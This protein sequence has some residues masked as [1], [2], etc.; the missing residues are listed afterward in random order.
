MRLSVII[1]TKNEESQIKGCLDSIKWTDE[2]IVVDS[3]S[4]DRTL[5]IAKRYNTKIFTDKGDDFSVKRNLGL[6]KTS[7]EW[8]FYVDADERV[9]PELREE[10]KSVISNQEAVVSAYKIPRKNFY[11]GNNEW[12]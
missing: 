4:T 10:I 7:G 3:G 2:V 8:V 5:E 6:E 11:F 1:L 9:T 12:P